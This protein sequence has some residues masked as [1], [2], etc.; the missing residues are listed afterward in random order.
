ML[1]KLW[2]DRNPSFAFNLNNPNETLNSKLFYLLNKIPD[3]AVI[4]FA[5]LENEEGI[6]VRIGK[7]T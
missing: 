2:I 5:S 6:N 7:C 1:G 3:L 4:Q